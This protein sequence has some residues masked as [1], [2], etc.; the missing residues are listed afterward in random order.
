MFHDAQTSHASPMAVRA[1]IILKTL[2]TRIRQTYNIDKTMSIDRTKKGPGVSLK[3]PQQTTGNATLRRKF[4]YPISFGTH[5]HDFSETSNEGLVTNKT[6][7]TAQPFHTFRPVDC[8][9]DFKASIPDTSTTGVTIPELH[10]AHYDDRTC[11]NFRFDESETHCLFSSPLPYLP[12]IYHRSS[13]MEREMGS[14]P[15]T[16]CSTVCEQKLEPNS[17]SSRA[18]FDLHLSNSELH[19]APGERQPYPRPM[20]GIPE[21]SVTISN[22]SRLAPMDHP[23][24]FSHGLSFQ[25][26]FTFPFNP[27][28]HQ[29]HPT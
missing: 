6:K 14:G 1:V 9:V 23:F 25:F 3:S 12:E 24:E 19:L 2:V 8:E 13:S 29:S 4:S 17:T 18:S 16:T 26:M 27:V 20:I 15:S 5:K 21:R 10:T 7:P 11:S 22:E 28:H